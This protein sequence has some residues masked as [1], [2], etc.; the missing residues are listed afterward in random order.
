MWVEIKVGKFFY[1]LS[2]INS[3]INGSYKIYE[4]VILS[5][6]VFVWTMFCGFP[7]F[8]L[9]RQ[10]ISHANHNNFYLRNLICTKYHVKTFEK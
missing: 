8:W 6:L 5:E 10:E 1:L 9:F 2:R 7:G 4:Y 3:S